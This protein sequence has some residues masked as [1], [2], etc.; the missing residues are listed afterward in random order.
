[1]ASPT[2][3]ITGAAGGIGT[4]LRRAFHDVYQMRLLDRV[5]I[6]DAN[7]HE[8]LTADIG[9]LNKMRQACRAIDTVV[10]L[11]ACPRTDADF[12]T[13]LPLN[14]VGSYNVFQAANEQGC[15]RMIFASS[16]NAVNGYPREQIVRGD[17]P[18]N[19]TNLY[20]VTKCYGEALGR[21]YA[22]NGLST[23]CIRIGAALKSNDPPRAPE[24]HPSWITQRDLAQLVQRCIDVE[25][26]DFAIVH[27]LSGH[28]NPPLDLEPTYRLLGY[29]PQDGA[30]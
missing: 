29:N 14:I 1:M 15:R 6:E 17:M 12:D 21:F 9:D 22:N 20:G 26:I 3:L 19:P 7:G 25:G 24:T 11:A 8:V 10:H 30:L 27:G 18:I 28:A 2:V 16:I 5:P 23:I 4:N 13:L